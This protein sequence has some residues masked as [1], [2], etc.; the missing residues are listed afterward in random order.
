MPLDELRPAE[1]LAAQG[2]LSRVEMQN[3]FGQKHLKID[4]LPPSKV[5]TILVVETDT[6][7]SVE[8]YYVIYNYLKEKHGVSKMQ[9]AWSVDNLQ[10]EG[11]VSD[12]HLS[13]HLR[14]AE[15]KQEEPVV[16]PEI[17]IEEV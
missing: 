4:D 6:A 2:T 17:E 13:A 16:D 10:E 15:K 3:R 9:T 5:T 8:E 12:L 14:F 7:I 11:Y 1:D